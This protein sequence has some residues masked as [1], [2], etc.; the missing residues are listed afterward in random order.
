V[1][2]NGI[3]AATNSALLDQLEIGGASGVGLKGAA[4]GWVSLV[5]TMTVPEGLFRVTHMSM[6]FVDEHGSPYAASHG[7]LA[8]S[9]AVSAQLIALHNRSAARTAVATLTSNDSRTFYSSTPQ[10]LSVA[11]PNCG[12]LLDPYESTYYVELSVSR[13]VAT[14]NPRIISVR[15]GNEV[16]Q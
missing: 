3:N 9:G 13:S 5:C 11:L 2:K 4:V 8:S 7:P 15:L 12:V 1:T 6:T 16:C 14:L 10:Q